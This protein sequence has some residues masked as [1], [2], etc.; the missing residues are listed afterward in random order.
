MRR[1]LSI[2][3]ATIVSAVAVLC[4]L[5]L[6]GDDNGIIQY[7]GTQVIATEEEKTK[8]SKLEKG[9][10]PTVKITKSEQGTCYTDE[11]YRIENMICVEVDNHVFTGKEAVEKGIITQ[12]ETEKKENVLCFP[13]AGIYPVKICVLDKYNERHIISCMIPVEIMWEGAEE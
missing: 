11:K 4:V 9:V 7:I 1:L 2:F 12:I 10:L 8:I 3:G 5:S 13:K 6:L